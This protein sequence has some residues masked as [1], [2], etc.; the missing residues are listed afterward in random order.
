MASSIHFEDFFFI[1][2]SV[3]WHGIVYYQ[4]RL[5]PGSSTNRVSW[6]YILLCGLTMGS[7]G[8]AYWITGSESETITFMGILKTV[9]SIYM[10]I[11]Q[12]I[13]NYRRQSTYGWSVLNCILDVFAGIL[14]ILQ[15]TIDYCGL[16]LPEDQRSEA[17]DMNVAKL[18]LGLT[19]VVFDILFIYQHF[20]LYRGNIPE[21]EGY[22]PRRHRVESMISEGFLG[23][24]TNNYDLIKITTSP[25]R[26]RHESL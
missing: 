5:Y 21:I 23:P 26:D 15:V 3:L 7:I 25:D 24:M 10:L 16:D 19:C 14:S 22:T 9:I 18:S 4:M 12:A 20:V 2:C 17:R 1:I 13:L 8:I 6:F 11:P